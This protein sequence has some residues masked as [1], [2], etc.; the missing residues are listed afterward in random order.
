MQRDGWETGD[1]RAP[2]FPARGCACGMREARGLSGAVREK[3]R[4]SRT[5]G[6]SSEDWAPPRAGVRRCLCH[7]DRKGWHHFNPTSAP[8][9]EPQLT[10]S[11]RRN[12]SSLVDDFSTLTSLLASLLLHH[13]LLTELILRLGL[14]LPQTLFIPSPNFLI[15]LYL[16]RLLR[17]QEGQFGN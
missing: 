11:C 15:S 2:G 3:G 10:C 6:R 13:F 4:R 16:L 17:A 14:L 9:S 1:R 12:L 7:Q 8:R 5:S